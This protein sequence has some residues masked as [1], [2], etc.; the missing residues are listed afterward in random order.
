M[1]IFYVIYYLTHSFHLIKFIKD[2]L[3]NM[4]NDHKIMPI[5]TYLVNQIKEV[6]QIKM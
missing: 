5:Y 2:L 6:F 3:M 4:I 1:I